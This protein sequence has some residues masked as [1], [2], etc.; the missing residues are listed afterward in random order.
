MK[1]LTKLIIII[2][3]VSLKTLTFA[4]NRKSWDNQ[5]AAK[6][7]VYI[8]QSGIADNKHTLTNTGPIPLTV[9]DATKPG[10]DLVE[11]I[12]VL[13][14][15]L[16]SDPINSSIEVRTKIEDYEKL[17]GLA[18][19][20]SFDNFDYFTFWNEN[21]WYEDGGR[22]D[23][24]VSSGASIGLS[25]AF[26]YLIGVIQDPTNP[27]SLVLADTTIPSHK[28][29]YHGYRYRALNILIKLKKEGKI[30]FKGSPNLRFKQYVQY[31]SRE[32]IAYTTTYD[33]L[34]LAYEHDDRTL[35]LGDL[36]LAKMALQGTV[37]N[38]YEAG[39]SGVKLYSNNHLLVYSAALGLA[40]NVLND[41]GHSKRRKK[42]H[43]AKWAEKANWWI[44]NTLFENGDKGR[45]S[46]EDFMAGYAE[47]P[48]YFVYAMEALAPFFL[49]Y[50]NM[51]NADFEQKVKPKW[52]KKSH[53]I[54][55]Y[56]YTDKIHRLY[57]WYNYI[58]MPNGVHPPYDASHISVEYPYG[59]TFLNSGK[60]FCYNGS[61]S[62]S[63]TYG[64]YGVLHYPEKITSFNKIQLR[65][66]S[67]NVVIPGS[68]DLVLQTPFTVKDSDRIYLHVLNET[69]VAVNGGAHEHADPNSIIVG[70]GN[71][72]LLVDPGYYKYEK[73]GKVNKSKHHNIISHDDKSVGKKDTRNVSANMLPNA[74]VETPN[75][76]SAVSTTTYSGAKFTKRCTYRNTSGKQYFV[77]ADI[78]DEDDN[79][80]AND[81]WS[82]QLH[83]NGTNATNGTNENIPSSAI[84]SFEY[85]D[86]VER[87]LRWKYP[88]TIL[89]NT[90]GIQTLTAVVGEDDG[91]WAEDFKN[92]NEKSSISV[93]HRYKDGS[94]IGDHTRA[95]INKF[96]D[97]QAKFLTV[98]WPYKCVDSASVPIMTKIQNSDDVLI[99]IQD[100][101][102]EKITD[103]HAL[104]PGNLLITYIDPLDRNPLESVKFNGL[105][106]MLSVSEDN[107]KN[108]DYCTSVTKFRF[109]SLGDG[110][111]LLYNDTAYIASTETVTA[112]Y[113]LSGKYKY[114]GYAIN[115]HDTD[116]HV[117]MLI[118]DVDSTIDMVVRD[119]ETRDSL[120]HPYVDYDNVTREITF[121][122]KA[123]TTFR[124]R[125]EPADLCLSACFFPDTDTTIYKTFEF[126]TGEDE[127]LGHHLD[128][129]Q[130]SG[131]LRITNGSKMIICENQLLA[132]QDSIV[133]WGN[134]SGEPQKG[135]PVPPSI[136]YAESGPIPDSMK[137]SSF[138]NRIKSE[139]SMII[140]ED[141]A[142]LVL[143]SHS[144]THIGS[145]STIYIE[146]GGTLLIEDS[147]EVEIGGEGLGSGELIAEPG[148]YVCV[149]DSADL[150]FFESEYDDDDKN[151]FFVS[152]SDYPHLTS[153]E[154][155]MDAI[156]D[157]F[158][159]DSIYDHSKYFCITF[160]ELKDILPPD[161]INN[162]DFG[163][164]NIS[165]PRARINMK[166]TFCYGS[167][168]LATLGK[169]LNE[170][171]NY[172][173]INRIDTNTMMEVPGSA[174][175]FPDTMLQ[176][177]DTLRVVKVFLDELYS[178]DFEA[179]N[180]Y[181]LQL[182]TENDC[183]EKSDSLKYFWID[184][185]P[186]PELTSPSAACPGYET[187]T[188]DGSSSTYGESYQWTISR[189]DTFDIHDNDTFYEEHEVTYSDTSITGAYS[190]MT[191]PDYRVYGGYNYEITLQ[192]FSPGCGI[193]E[194][195]DTVNIPLSARVKT[196]FSTIIIGG[197][198][199]SAQLTGAV[200]GAVSFDWTPTSGLSNSTILTPKA[201][202]SSTTSY[203]LTGYFG[204]CTESD[205]VEIT[206]NLYAYA[207]LDSNMCLG[208]SVGIGS[209]ITLP[210]G[211]SIEWS[212][213]TGLS[214][215][216]VAQP[217]ASPEETTIY[218]LQ[219]FDEFDVL[220]EV[221]QVTVFV[222]KPLFP[223]FVLG[224]ID[225]MTYLFNN[226]T[227]EY[228]EFASY[229]WYFGDGDSS[230]EM[231]P[232][233]EYSLTP[234]DTV[235]NVYITLISSNLCGD[236]SAVDSIAVDTVGDI[237]LAEVM[238]T[239][240]DETDGE[241]ASE[242]KQGSNDN[243]VTPKLEDDV[244]PNKNT[245]S[246]DE[247][248]L[249]PNPF[250]QILF[251]D[252][253]IKNDFANA[254]LVL[255]VLN[256]SGGMVRKLNL[257]PE[258]SQT[259]RVDLSGQPT[260]LYYIRIIRDKEVLDIKKALKS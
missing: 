216:T 233:H 154:L 9:W 123:N 10:F 206:V 44:E 235:Y 142:A 202:P 139:R 176:G 61:F 11:E 107:I 225:S 207:G 203:I 2:C 112:G 220:L 227:E 173:K 73:R 40:S 71:E 25:A 68:G 95:K 47:G 129:V 39:G 259:I 31:R 117:T 78:A 84:Q 250:S 183:D 106:M 27:D 226:R 109:A 67:N 85:K 193:I 104:G 58:A 132:N 130:D 29:F 122:V 257:T 5:K 50:K 239:A 75:T 241:K 56:D 151:V 256:S 33:L 166:D 115:K 155:N 184:P 66:Y 37:A 199:D 127:R 43:S 28:L 243:K 192:A 125:L 64:I 137:Y 222:S 171:K 22:F 46:E 93:S 169:T 181:S 230:A 105:E 221:D 124:F 14:E 136:G 196:D 172:I 60:N 147:C 19:N 69:G 232:I 108:W 144:H 174:E 170:T 236:S 240:S 12:E 3:L 158:D 70:A 159:D 185:L 86:T 81:L 80:G 45:M 62:G 208:D 72:M 149:T 150:H 48:H 224:Y 247:I 114:I 30:K 180:L 228:D 133:M 214:D 57:E 38:F 88:C 255:E 49:S 17:L 210:P 32:I 99:T 164:S 246:H 113:E 126:G 205:T 168:V 34:R 100:I 7:G 97:N 101:G 134:N 198:P 110:S 234:R 161:G 42:Y 89:R 94:W 215:S 231:S 8:K 204:T 167:N 179:E 152:M 189:I 16:L 6:H 98:M 54:T 251:V 119:K 15:L 23:K 103:F 219:I 212:P 13:Q 178:F 87:L 79:G 254:N 200:T 76:A 242:L 177:W 143:E 111:D 52:R 1:N 153:P 116:I 21:S 63:H 194:K 253:N 82:Y 135:Y 65:T 201:S 195:I 245:I 157:K 140:V 53:T 102:T 91:I 83:G 118:P 41:V 36:S 77:M 131:L 186:V 217:N 209:S 175:I 55:N 248:V 74:L 237:V 18:D 24:H 197:T 148:S 90:Y 252:V 182:F 92:G 141:K 20:D 223:E 35:D 26:V 244:S 145:F 59:F 138:Q 128:I 162:K 249:R 211:Y 191:F 190:N 146:R 238:P 187:I 165:T 156:Y 213:G 258:N 121:V 218:T 120:K 229:K 160:C 163:W 4:Q 96:A 260:G 51:F 188:C